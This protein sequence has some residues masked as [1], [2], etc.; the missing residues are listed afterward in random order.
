[1]RG[2]ACGLAWGTAVGFPAHT[3]CVAS[4]RLGQAHRGQAP[5]VQAIAPALTPGQSPPL[6][7]P[8]SARHTP[9]TRHRPASRMPPHTQIPTSQAGPV[10]AREVD[11]VADHDPGLHLLE[12]A[13]GGAEQRVLPWAGQWHAGV[14]GRLPRPPRHLPCGI[15]QLLKPH[16]QVVGLGRHD[17]ARPG[18][19]GAEGGQG[20]AAGLADVVVGRELGA[21]LQG[22]DGGGCPV[23]ASPFPAPS[24]GDACQQQGWLPRGCNEGAKG[25]ASQ[26]RHRLHGID[27]GEQC[28]PKTR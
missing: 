26:A 19:Q 22:G 10:D 14:L 11:P 9:P 8:W 27:W 28:V 25:G 21:G 6:M 7:P 23:Q 4:L 2:W 17:L 15:L 13:P 12:Q 1:M 18:Q 3:P 20:H 24:P 16:A 5:H